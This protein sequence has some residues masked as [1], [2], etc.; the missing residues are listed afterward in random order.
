[1]YFEDII[2]SDKLYSFAVLFVFAIQIQLFSSTRICD[3]K[4]EF[5]P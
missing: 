1:M 3:K 2:S 5:L 4:D